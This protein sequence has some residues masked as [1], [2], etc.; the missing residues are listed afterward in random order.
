MHNM[1]FTRAYDRLV[2]GKEL[3]ARTGRIP[4]EPTEAVGA[5]TETVAAQ[6]EA[7]GASHDDVNP[8]PKPASSITDDPNS[9]PESTPE[10]SAARRR[11]AAEALAPSEANGIGAPIFNGDRFITV[12]TDSQWWTEDRSTLAKGAIPVDEYLAR[13]REQRRRE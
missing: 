12:L 6:N 10:E 4:G 13:A 3:T 9:T 11:E 5:A 2:K 7:N 1:D 8:D